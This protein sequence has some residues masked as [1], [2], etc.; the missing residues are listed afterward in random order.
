MASLLFAAA[1]WLA[2]L[3]HLAFVAWVLMG[4]WVGLVWRRAIWWHVPVFT[5]AVI[6][7]AIRFQC[8]LTNFEKWLWVQSGY[9]SYEGGF[10]GYYVEPYVRALGVPRLIYANMGY[11]T[12]GINFV[13]YGWL[14]WRWWKGRL[15]SGHHVSAV[16]TGDCDRRDVGERDLPDGRA[17][18]RDDGREGHR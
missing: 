1:A 7:E 6:I 18:L 13:L 16:T 2:M 3:S 11:W 9:R 12:V 10:L 17:R 14:V 5:Y 8:P 4:G 15:H